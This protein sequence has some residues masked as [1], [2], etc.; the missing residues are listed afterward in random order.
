MRLVLLLPLG[1]CVT[2][3]NGVSTTTT[4]NEDAGPG[5]ITVTP[6]VLEFTNLDPAFAKSL[7]FTVSSDGE[8]P[9]L[10]YTVRIVQSAGDVFHMDEID[11]TITLQPGETK[12][13]SVA[14]VMPEA[15]QAE[16]TLRIE[17]NDPEDSKFYLPLCAVTEG[18]EATPCPAEDTGD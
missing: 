7:E 17:S 1:A 13:W 11:E 16:G 10:L 9:L 8:N 2:Q 14:A 3:D 5:G 15:G 18:W 12:T 6:E 4:T